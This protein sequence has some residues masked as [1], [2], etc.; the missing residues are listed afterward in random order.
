MLAN[1]RLLFGLLWQPITAMQRLRERSAVAFAVSVAWL[2]T[3]LYRGASSVL[4]DY[5]QDGRL[6]EDIQNGG[7][8][9]SRFQILSGTVASAGMWAVM[10]V[11]FVAVIYV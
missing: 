2:M 10:V 3:F 4:V 5:A 9:E 7:E 1:L 6:G 11:L 8:V